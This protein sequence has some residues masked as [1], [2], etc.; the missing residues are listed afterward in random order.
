MG[1]SDENK[2]SQLANTIVKDIE[3]YYASWKMPLGLGMALTRYNRQIR[4]MGH[5]TSSFAIEL[6]ELGLVDLVQ[7]PYNTKYFF[8]KG[9]EEQLDEIELMNQLKSAERLKNAKRS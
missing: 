2:F 7:T 1:P 8:P 9:T 5:T 4:G 6:S 3:K